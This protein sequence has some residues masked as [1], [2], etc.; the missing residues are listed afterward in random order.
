MTKAEFCIANK[1]SNAGNKNC[2]D[3]VNALEANAGASMKRTLN[4]VVEVQYTTGRLESR[5]E[6]H[7]FR[8]PKRERFLPRAQRAARRE[9]AATA[10]GAARGSSA[11]HGTSRTRSLEETSIRGI[12]LT[13][14]A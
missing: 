9:G 6:C 7:G 13:S 2:G 14:Y 1:T 4:A 5:S 3:R 11:N 12:E 8:S 10:L